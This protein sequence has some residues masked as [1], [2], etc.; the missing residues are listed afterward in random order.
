MQ[1]KRKPVYTRVKCTL[2]SIKG[3]FHACN[4]VAERE[5]ETGKTKGAG[6]QLTERKK[7]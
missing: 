4:S 2:S 3:E 6:E 1:M 7:E 5:S